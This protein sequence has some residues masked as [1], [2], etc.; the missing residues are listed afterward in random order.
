MP[1]HVSSLELN[2]ATIL[3]P[4]YVSCTGF[5]SSG[6]LNTRSRVSITSRCQARH[7]CVPG[8][9]HQP[10]CRQWSPFALISFHQD[11]HRP[12]STKQFRRQKLQCCQPTCMVTCTV[13][14]PWLKLA[15][16]IVYSRVIE[17]LPHYTFVI[18]C[19]CAV[20]GCSFCVTDR[21]TRTYYGDD[22]DGDD[23]LL[24]TAAILLNGLIA[25]SAL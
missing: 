5:P 25:S 3:C 24:T 18:L 22:D 21:L 17:L 23:E 13:F 8:E 14:S 7:L 19:H 12:T 20:T 6:E 16:A 1:L 2:S 11:M 4:C 15:R 10:H 9:W